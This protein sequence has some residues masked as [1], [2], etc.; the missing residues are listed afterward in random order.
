MT[1]WLFST[2]SCS[3]ANEIGQFLSAIFRNGTASFGGYIVRLMIIKGKGRN[4]LSVYQGY[5]LNPIRFINVADYIQF[6]GGRAH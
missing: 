6:S 4:D 5:G 3:A 1:K 2:T